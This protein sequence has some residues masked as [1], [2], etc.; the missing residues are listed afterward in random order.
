MVP[1]LQVAILLH[2]LWH[3]CFNDRLRFRAWLQLAV[4]ICDEKNCNNA[5]VRSCL[6]RYRYLNNKKSFQCHS[7]T[8]P[9]DVLA[10]QYGPYGRETGH[11]TD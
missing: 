8:P 2:K 1:A 11:L 9:W 3:F 6:I 7:I 10:A 5:K 4:P